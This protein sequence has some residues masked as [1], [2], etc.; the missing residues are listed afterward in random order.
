MKLYV[1]IAGVVLM[2]SLLPVACGGSPA[3]SSVAT[4]TARPTLTPVPI[5]NTEATPTTAP[6]P[7]VTDTPTPTGSYR[8][9]ILHNNDGESQLVDLGSGLE[10]FG[11]VAHFATV[12]QREKWA[13]SS[14]EG[15]SEKSG[16]IMVSSGDNFLAGPEFTAGLRSGTYYDALALDL[17][18]YDAIALG[19]HDFDFGP[20]VLAEFIKQVSDSQAPFLSSNL[21]F[22]GEPSLQALFDEGRIAESVVVQRNGVRIGIIGVTTPNLRSISSPRNVKIISGVAGEIQAEVDRLEAAGVNKIVLIS[23]LQDVDVDIALLKQIDGVDVVVAGGGDDLLANPRDPLVPG[24]EYPRPYPIIATDLDGTEVPVV[25]TAGQYGY[26]GKLVVQFDGG[27]N[28]TDIDAEASGPIR[29]AHW[30][31][32]DAVRP[33]PD[34]QTQVVDPVVRF[35][36]DLTRAIATSQVVLEGRRSEVRSRETNQGNLM[37]DALHRKAS[38][39]ADEYAVSSPDVAI[40]NGGGIRNGVLLPA[41]PITEL[42]TFDMAPFSNLVTVLENIS[43]EQFKEVLENAV[44]RAVDGDTE[45]GSGRFA[46]VSGFSFEWSESG[47]AQV[48]GPDG[49]VD[50]PGARVQRVMLN[51]GTVIVDGGA[52]MPGSALTVATIDFLARGGDQYPYRGAPFTN[53]GVSYQQ[54]LADYIQDT[55]GLYGTVTAA[56]YPEGGEGRIV[57]L[58]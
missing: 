39:L 36:E 54:A 58:P 43:R 55:D 37:A 24:D 38:Q 50:T 15:A 16:W 19:N 9:T 20:E 22:S 2:V 48:L 35:I 11:G 41:G 40:Q 46:Q 52:V 53:M 13:A 14:D 10:D 33:Q 51:D 56:D 34:V 31:N 1:L 29:I 26:L 27:G 18:G 57:R 6:A 23:H 3:S 44:S 5:P 17:I 49:T 25:T 45:G 7:T 32:P 12:V 21:D 42:D 8:L 28:L 4:V 30:I 47:T